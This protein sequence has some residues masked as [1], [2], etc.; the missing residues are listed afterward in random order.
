[1]FKR[2]DLSSKFSLVALA[3][4]VVLG[5]VVGA[6]AIIQSR[7]ASATAAES[8][9]AAIATER[10]SAL[11][12]YLSAIEVDLLTTA[13]N[14]NT[15]NA[16][17]DFS[18]AW[19]G[20]PQQR[21]TLQRLYID[22]NPHPTGQKEN[23]DFAADGSA[24]SGVHRE[25]HP[26]FREFL[27]ARGYY[28]IFLFDMQ[29]N[30]VYSVFKEL[31]YATNLNTGEYRETDLGNAFR[32]AL[33]VS[34]GE[35]SFF[36]FQAY[37]PSHGAP[38]SFM[39]TPVTDSSGRVSGALVFQM[40][41]DRLNAVMGSGAGLQESGDAYAIGR[42]GL[43]RTQPRFAQDGAILSTGVG[44]EFASRVTTSSAGV[45]SLEDFR[46]EK[47][48]VAFAP[49]EFE[50][51]HWSVVVTQNVGEAMSAAT[52]LTWSIG[53]V[54]IFVTGVV[55]VVAFYLSRKVAR[56]LVDIAETTF[57]VGRGD[58]SRV[59]PHLDASDEVGQLAKAVEAF[60]QSSE[61]R[62]QMESQKA[63][64]QATYIERQE[65]L[66][67]L[68]DGFQRTISGIAT[69]VS[70]AAD[71]FNETS[72]ALTV[73]ATSS[74]EKAHRAADASSNATA[75][76]ESIA[77]ATEEMAATVREIGRQATESSE[78]SANAEKIA[79]D[80]VSQVQELATAA[81]RIGEVIT[82]IQDIAE[83]TNLLALNATI[84]AAR[85]GEAGKGFAIV[86]SEVKQ[87][88]S[89]T[90]QA[91]GQISQQISSIQSATDASAA[92][93]D[94]VASEIASLSEIAASIAGAVEQ[95]TAAT[96]EIA[97]SVQS[98]VEGTRS[99]SS[100]VTEV[101]AAIDESSTS[102]L[103]V[104]ENAEELMGLAEMLSRE[105]TV[106]LDGVKAA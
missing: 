59:V 5:L 63:E 54:T 105:V 85:A 80:S 69:T 71:Q 55:G 96:Q 68:I 28:D 3:G 91:T 6:A 11:L 17:N 88:A 106:F 70:G 89:Q 30:L 10:Q 2:L 20:L 57:A 14:Q 49:V 74:T 9:L 41:I 101:S 43:M 103:Q 82:I 72:S 12:N 52:S 65:R 95:Q 81:R 4:C 66:Q 62:E 18:A 94:T 47:V 16:L 46:G 56:P 67:I 73:M 15:R 13:S 37:S 38:A 26:W 50:G 24:Y 34:P 58:L 75:S 48:F 45:A 29:G 33:E 104:S 27:R 78:R 87:L 25:Y 51:V 42:D 44:G 7:N 22:Q 1:M 93:I 83:Q 21:Q 60:R 79:S 97:Q 77:T 32:A 92:A 90:E 40:P 61:I 102:A 99:A 98:T 64:E 23:L 19:D 31:D 36:D 53:L 39:S 35:V 76:V 8:R 84:E 100:N 86:A